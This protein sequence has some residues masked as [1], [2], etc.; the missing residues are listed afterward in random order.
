MSHGDSTK[1]VD[2]AERAVT[3]LPNDLLAV[4]VMAFA[5]LDAGRNG[6]ALVFAR[7]AVRLNPNFSDSHRLLAFALLRLARY[8]EA[9]EAAR[10]AIE[11]NPDNAEA[12]NALGNIN[13][14]QRKF[15]QAAAAYRSALALKPTSSLYLGN[16]AMAEAPPRRDPGRSIR[17]LASLA[18]E[19]PDMGLVL[20]NMRAATERILI[21][22]L[23]ILGA[24][25]V[26]R[27]A[28]AVLVVLGVAVGEIIQVVILAVP[29]AALVGMLTTVLVR[30]GPRRLAGWRV[31]WGARD[32]RR[33]FVLEGVEALLA[34]ASSFAPAVA[35]LLLAVPSI[36]TI[37]AIYAIWRVKYYPPSR[38]WSN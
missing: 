9:I 32:Q 22:I 16:L 7:S 14:R 11:L 27:C 13:L 36:G 33:I 23:W 31:L 20:H 3:V 38:L 18:A 12:F 34:I 10:R 15:P 28:V 21:W 29:L 2:Y 37:I 26:F 4:R 5:Y 25:L 8:S 35:V 17:R 6:D 24:E 1:A 30:M 19:R